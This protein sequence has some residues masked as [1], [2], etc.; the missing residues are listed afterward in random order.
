VP[1]AAFQSHR[2][3]LGTSLDAVRRTAL[4]S[5]GISGAHTHAR[6]HTHARARTTQEGKGAILASDGMH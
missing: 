2:D 6:T 1:V 4:K 5:K 3:L